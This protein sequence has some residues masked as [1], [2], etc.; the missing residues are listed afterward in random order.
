MASIKYSG[1][2]SEIKGKLNGSILSA[3]YGGP[4]IRNRKSGRVGLTTRNLSA[5]AIMSY[6]SSTWR[7][8]TSLQRDAWTAMAPSYPYINK[9]GDPK[10]PSGFQLYCTLNS[11]LH[12]VALPLLST[13]INPPIQRNLGVFSLS[14]TGPTQLQINW[15]GSGATV[16]SLVISASPVVSVGVGV[17]PRRRKNLGAFATNSVTFADISS[18]YSAA[19]GGFTAGSRIWVNYSIIDKTSGFRYGNGSTFFDFP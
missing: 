1:L 19:Y 2:V 8:L 16:V 9:F 6:I 15:S 17:S 10:T 3:G 13:P 7:S 14:S 5:L 4:I 18:S 12:L 11:N